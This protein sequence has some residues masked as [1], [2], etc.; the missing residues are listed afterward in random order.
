MEKSAAELARKEL[1][2]AGKTDKELSAAEADELKQYAKEIEELNEGVVPQ[3]VKI[4]Q[5]TKLHL[6]GKEVLVVEQDSTLGDLARSKYGNADKA[7]LLYDDNKETLTLP[8]V[9]PA[10]VSLKVPQGNGP[11]LLAFGLLTLFLIMVGVGFILPAPALASTSP[12]E[13]Y[14]GSWLSPNTECS[15]REETHPHPRT[16]GIAYDAEFA[17]R[18]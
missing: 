4:S 6:P 7:Q 18:R 5:G 9:L 16:P 2:L 8:E 10:G 11:A 12:E 15:R 3:Y 17:S 14:A 1:H 13:K